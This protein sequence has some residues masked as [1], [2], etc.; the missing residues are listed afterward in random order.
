M[1]TFLLFLL[2]RLNSV[3]W[4]SQHASFL[5]YFASSSSKCVIIIE[6]TEIQS[7]FWNVGFSG[8]GPPGGRNCKQ[9]SFVT[10]CKSET[11]LNANNLFVSWQRRSFR[12]TW[13]TG[14]HLTERGWPSWSS[15][16]VW[17]PTWL[18]LASLGW[19]TPKESSTRTLRSVPV[20][21]SLC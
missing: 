17:C 8:S 12:P 14:G 6:M 9:K 3:W 16:T 11:C 2:R 10:C 4:S 5:C 13:L 18:Y 20:P 1:T 21:W 7:L 19:R 15:T